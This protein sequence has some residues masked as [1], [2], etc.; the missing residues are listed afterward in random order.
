MQSVHEI[1]IVSIFKGF[2]YQILNTE[3]VGNCYN[4]VSFL[5]ATVILS[6]GPTTENTNLAHFP[7][8]FLSLFTIIN[9]T[10]VF[11]KGLIKSE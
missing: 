4:T 2:L 6:H 3:K 1:G 8:F 7:P 9:V 10:E 5:Y 11:K